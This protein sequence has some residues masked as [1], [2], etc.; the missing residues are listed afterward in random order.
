M[1]YPYGNA[2]TG[3]AG[4]TDWAFST[5][6]GIQTDFTPNTNRIA[7]TPAK[8][9]VST[10]S[11]VTP[12]KGYNLGEKINLVQIAT[13]G[14]GF[15]FT[16][17]ATII[18]AGGSLKLNQSVNLSNPFTTYQNSL[19]DNFNLDNSD[20]TYARRTSTGAPESFRS[21]AV[22]VRSTSGIGVDA[23]F[24]FI[25]VNGSI[26]NVTVATIGS[27]YKAGDTLTF[28][29]VSIEAAI[30]GGG[31]DLLGNVTLTLTSNDI[32]GGLG[33][34]QI[35]NGGVGYVAADTITL[36]EQGSGETGTGT[37]TV[38]TLGTASTIITA[39]NNIYPRA[40][41][42]A[43]GTL[44]APKTIEFVGLDDIDVIIGGL[45]TGQILPFKFKQIKTT[46][47]GG[48]DVT[49]GLTTIFY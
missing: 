19:L 22:A 33:Q 46:S 15:G 21:T 38:A 11:T 13:S 41:R 12:G 1:I 23:T 48:T 10:I 31:I 40:V 20:Y 4:A 2:K 6:L 28:T 44:A 30:P 47:V 39:P 49:L 16:A 27:N 14:T 24:R 3:G 26:T 42:C 32:S 18:E 25:A 29:D 45:V 17:I 35:L 7:R 5:D 43:E 8:G 9:E 36:T 37:V 34:V